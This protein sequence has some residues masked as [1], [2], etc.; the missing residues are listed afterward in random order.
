ME[1]DSFLAGKTLS[2]LSAVAERYG[3]PRFAAA[4]MASWLYRRPVRRIAD[5]TNLSKAARERLAAD[6]EIGYADPVEANRST[7]GTVKYLFAVGSDF[8]ESVYIPDGD[9]ATLC[10]SSQVGCKMNCAFCMTG[11]QGFTRNLTAAEIINQVVSIPERDSL[12]NIVFMGMG[13]PLDNIDE[14]MKAL[15]ILTAEWGFAWSPRRITLSTV[16]LTD[17]LCRFLDESRCHLAV[18]LHNPFG[19]ERAAMMPIQKAMPIEKTVE[20]LRRYDFSHQR[21]LSFEYIVFEGINDTPAHIDALGRL[22]KGL[23]CRINLIRFHVIPQLDLH[24]PSVEKMEVFRDA[25]SRKGLICTI[26][27]SRGEDVKA[28]CGMLSTARKQSAEE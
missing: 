15:E 8:V 25:L 3:M 12:T 26:R 18:S 5:M 1:T 23:E 11:R 10:V 22:L 20:L 16:G 19:E 2:E 27:A 9:R 7:D 6:F 28:A 13:E 24:S 14:V 4:Q 21:R 17:R